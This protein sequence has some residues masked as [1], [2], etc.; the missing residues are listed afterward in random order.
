MTK[1]DQEELMRENSG[2]SAGE[3]LRLAREKAGMSLQD[4]ATKLHLDE[5]VVDALEREDETHLPSKVFT[6]GYLRKYA[7]L[8]GLPDDSV[9]LASRIANETDNEPAIRY[10]PAPEIRPQTSSNHI[11]VKL[12]TWLIIIA[13][14]ALLVSWWQGFVKIPG[15]DLSLSPSMLGNSQS[16]TGSENGGAEEISLDD[17]RSEAQAVLDIPSGEISLPLQELDLSAGEAGED[18]MPVEPEMNETL[19]EQE[20]EPVMLEQSLP[21]EIDTSP[22]VPA[23]LIEQ[24]VETSEPVE[25]VGIEEKSGIVMR[26]N[27]RSWVDVRDA[28]NRIILVGEVGAGEMRVIEGE[29]PIRFVIGNAPGVAVEIDGQPFD[30]GA[31]TE[32]HVAR[33]ALGGQQ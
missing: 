3:L 25:S 9:I 27:K 2:P 18:S 1:N 19:L 12:F 16:M 29:P 5:Q 23:E 31:H 10:T 17:T 15:L 22:S 24:G 14:I 21:I 30:L 8:L 32:K 4:V 11:V 26:F 33:F 7:R 20:V 13:L 28:T 6:L